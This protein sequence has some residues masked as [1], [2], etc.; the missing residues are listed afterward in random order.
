MTKVHVRN[1]KGHA[2]DVPG[3]GSLAH[4]ESVEVERT[5]E[6]DAQIEAGALT[7]IKAEAKAQKDVGDKP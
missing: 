7:D 1:P 3:G 6:V 5:P 2:V 4:D